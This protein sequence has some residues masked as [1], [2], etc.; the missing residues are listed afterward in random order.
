MMVQKW[1]REEIL[2]LSIAL[3][4]ILFPAPIFVQQAS[5]SQAHISIPRVKGV[6]EIDVGP[7]TWKA[8]IRPD[9]KETQLQALHRADNLVIRAFMQKVKF[10]ASAQ[11]CR[12]EWWPMTAKS[13]PMKRDDLR[14]SERE[15]ITIVE[16]I[17][18]DFR[19]NPVRQKSLHAYLGIRD[20]CAEVHLSKMQFVTEDQKLFDDVLAT[21]RLSPDESPEEVL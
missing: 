3:T 16:Y 19:G 4:L 5:V 10:P 6:L 14:Q 12:D 2:K 11:K 17:I 1:P 9:G 8:S 13:S 20:L 15:G 21:V 18:P 7:T